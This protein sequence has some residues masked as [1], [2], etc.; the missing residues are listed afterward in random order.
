MSVVFLSGGQQVILD[1]EDVAK[2]SRRKYHI[3]KSTGV[4]QR[5]IYSK[6]AHKNIG[7]KGLAQDIMGVP[8]NRAILF[9]ND[10]KNDCRKK[11]LRVVPNSRRNVKA[12]LSHSNTSGYRGVS[13]N[14]DQKKFEAYIR[15]KY[16][17]YHLGSYATAEQAAAAYN[18]RAIKYFKEFAKLNII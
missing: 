2:F 1:A 4:I 14:V 18:S 13:Y 17:K 11:N 12:K 6:A 8:S 10:K 16:K 5:G 3:V 7:R 15:Y 9:L